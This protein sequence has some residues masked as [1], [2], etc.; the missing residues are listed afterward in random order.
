[1][2]ACVSY[3]RNTLNYLQR[4]DP[5]MV[6]MFWRRDKSVSFTVVKYF[7]ASVIVCDIPL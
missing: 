5:E 6:W 1:M 2:L 3:G 4:V 7:R